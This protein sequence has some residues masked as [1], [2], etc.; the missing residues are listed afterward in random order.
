MIFHLGPRSRG[1]NAI[2][3]NISKTMR[4]R[5]SISVVD[6]SEI[7]YGLSCG[8]MT[9]ELDPRSSGQYAIFANISKTMRDRDFMSFIDILE[10]IYRLSFCAMTLL[11]HQRSKMLSFL[12]NLANS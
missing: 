11:K 9:F 4:D 6:K 5:D 12:Q 1:K 10:I 8:A 3:T 2:F 7:I